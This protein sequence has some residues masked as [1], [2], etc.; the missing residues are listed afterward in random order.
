MK[1]APILQS[2]DQLHFCAVAIEQ[3]LVLLLE[4]GPGFSAL[5]A[6]HVSAEPD[7]GAIILE[8]CMQVRIEQNGTCY[9]KQFDQVVVVREDAQEHWI[10]SPDGFESIFSQPSA[11]PYVFVQLSQSGASKLLQAINTGDFDTVFKELCER[12]ASLPRFY[13]PTPYELRAPDNY[14]TG[15]NRF[16][17]AKRFL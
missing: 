2:I 7:N 17:E 8:E 12:F 14:A 11:D 4:N 3:P 10:A 5:F 13:S 6:A 15:R 1:T 9:R 16:T